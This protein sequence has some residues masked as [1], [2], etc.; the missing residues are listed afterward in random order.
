VAYYGYRYYDPKTGRWPSRDPIGEEGGINLYG[1]VGNNGVNDFDYHG[2]MSWFNKFI[3]KR[4]AS[5]L[6]NLALGNR[7]G[8]PNY[9][10][11]TWQLQ[12]SFTVFETEDGSRCCKYIV[13]KYKLSQ[14][15]HDE[16][17][18]VRDDAQEKQTHIDC[19][20]ECPDPTS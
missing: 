4:I 3:N 14:G 6:A 10:S 2:M 8:N 1:F 13:C 9:N 18:R 17:F 15:G 5:Y 19:D 7:T 11:P 12:D 20:Q 16:S